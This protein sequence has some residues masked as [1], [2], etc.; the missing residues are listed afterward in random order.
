M[1]IRNPESRLQKYF[2]EIRTFNEEGSIFMRLYIVLSVTDSF[3]FPQFLSYNILLRCI[4]KYF[5]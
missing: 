2:E 4:L 3:E 5:V 1:K